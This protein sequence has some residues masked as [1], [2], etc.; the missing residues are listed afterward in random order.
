MKRAQLLFTLCLPL[1]IVTK[2]W[3]AIY[4]EL[5]KSGVNYLIASLAIESIKK[6]ECAYVF[7][8][9]KLTAHSEVLSK[10]QSK[11]NSADMIEL[12]KQLAMIK[13]QIDIDIR[14]QLHEF[15]LKA[16]EKTACGMLSGYAI[17]KLQESEVSWN[18]NNLKKD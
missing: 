14:A 8:S 6:T 11:L 2:A 16:D 15:R 4:P 17:Q 1:C 3:G 9:S 18:F 12:P 13:T 10:V 5:R 7:K